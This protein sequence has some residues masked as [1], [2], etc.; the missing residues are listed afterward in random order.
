MRLSTTL[1][2]AVYQLAS[3]ISTQDCATFAR[4]AVLSNPEATLLNSSYPTE[5]PIYWDFQLSLPDARI[6]NSLFLAIGNGGM[7]GKYDTPANEFMWNINKGYAI[8]GCDSGHEASEI[9][10]FGAGGPGLFIDYLQHTEQVEAWIH[11]SIAMHTPTSREVVES[12]YGVQP[13]YSYFKGCSTGGAQEFALALLWPDLFDG[14]I[15]GCPANCKGAGFLPQPTLDFITSAV[16]D[17]CDLLDGVADRVLENPLVCD[18]DINTL[19]CEPSATDLSSCL[20]PAQITTVEAIYAGP[21]YPNGTQIYPGFPVS[22][23]IEWMRQETDLVQLFTSSILQNLVFKDLKYDIL[24]FNWD[25]DVDRVDREA[26]ILIDEIGVDFSRFKA[27]GGKMLVFQGWADQYIGAT[28]PIQ[29]LHQIEDSHGGSVSDFFNLFM[30]PGSG[31]CLASSKDPNV[32]GAYHILETLVD[33][34]ENGVPPEEV[35][36]DQPLNGEKVSRKLCPWPQT[37]RYVKG[38]V[39]DWTSYVCGGGEMTAS[40][41][42]GSIVCGSNYKS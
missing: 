19:A 8:A 32:P 37:A 28:W 7:A 41:E 5:T 12:F 13:E 6:Y 40:L 33:W 25:S 20:T 17:K 15:A 34:V 9:N 3:A 31:H 1:A 2:W 27:A 29:H 26:G 18:F 23:E 35:M 36:T 16:L 4:N 42:K 24:R 11:N 39:N 10:N 38:D 14:I 21:K 22:S 30:I